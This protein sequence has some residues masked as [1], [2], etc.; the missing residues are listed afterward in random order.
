MQSRDVL[1]ILHG[2][3]LPVILRRLGSSDEHY[4]FVGTCYMYGIMDGEAVEADRIA[5]KDCIVFTL[6]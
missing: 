4:E 1:A 2:C 5:G 3:R 6:V